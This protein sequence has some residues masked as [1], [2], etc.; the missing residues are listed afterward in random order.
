MIDI[1]ILAAI[2]FVILFKLKNQLGNVNDGEKEEIK[3]K[4]HSKMQEIQKEIMNQTQEAVKKASEINQ[5]SESV[6]NQLT[7]NLD[8]LSKKQLDKIL[9]KSNITLEFFI[10]GAKSAFEMTLKAFSEN[11]LQTLKQL[12]SDKI[13]SSFEQSINHRQN[14]GQKLTTNLIAIKNVEII[15][16]DL[17]GDEATIKLN[18]TS[19]QINY[20]QD[21]S[22][23]LIDGSKEEINELNDIWT[24]KKNISS[25]NPN[26][27]I[28]STN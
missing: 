16:V 9:K 15:K 23:N 22:N 7:S 4:L 6:K 26:W 17:V 19:K 3:K 11:D 14:L 20:I 25:E 5:K 8:D 13:Y 2:A 21:Q 10:N 18:F 28:F 12:L 24:F 27:T 1:L